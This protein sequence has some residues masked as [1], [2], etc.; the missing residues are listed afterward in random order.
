MQDKPLRIA[1]ISNNIFMD[2]EFD[3]VLGLICQNPQQVRFMDCVKAYRLLPNLYSDFSDQPLFFLR[4]NNIKPNELQSD[5]LSKTQGIIVNLS[6]TALD[7]NYL[8]NKAHSD[9]IMTYLKVVY[10]INQP[11]VFAIQDMKGIPV[12]YPTI[13]YVEELSQVTHE[14]IKQRK[15][16]TLPFHQT[17]DLWQPNPPTFQAIRE[18]LEVPDYIPFFSYNRTKPKSIKKFLKILIDKIGE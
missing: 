4:N 16:E 13:V 3:R 9:T 6:G 14:N 1:V 5:I 12:F 7:T 18:I 2:Y 10:R 17:D 15:N 8:A 11:T